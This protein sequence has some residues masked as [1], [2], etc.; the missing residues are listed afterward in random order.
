MENSLFFYG[1]QIVP[2][3]WYC[4]LQYLVLTFPTIGI[5]RSNRWK[6]SENTLSAC[7]FALAFASF[8]YIL[9]CLSLSPFCQSFN[10]RRFAPYWHNFSF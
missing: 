9:R 1:K 3:D 10:L 6:H 2:V 4:S 5:S 8:L 7:P